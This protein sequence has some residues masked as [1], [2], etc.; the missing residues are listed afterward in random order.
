[1][2]VL[3]D[4]AP[5]RLATKLGMITRPPDGTCSRAYIPKDSHKFDADG[6]IFYNKGL[7]PGNKFQ[8]FAVSIWIV[9]F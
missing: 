5:S 7:L 8:Y 9:S 1:M 2:L 3:A 6:V 4:G